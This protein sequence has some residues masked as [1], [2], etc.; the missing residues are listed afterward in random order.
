MPEG[1]SGQKVSGGKRWTECRSS[2]DSAASGT[3]F[4]S[5][6]E[7]SHGQKLVC[8][9]DLSLFSLTFLSG[10]K[11]AESTAEGPEGVLLGDPV[12]TPQGG[13]AAEADARLEPCASRSEC[14]DS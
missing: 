12:E 6:P 4:S 8:L 11:E 13:P 2:R 14:C 1:W 9:F 7:W 10:G 5:L 3:P